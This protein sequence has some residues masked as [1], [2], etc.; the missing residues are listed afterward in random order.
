MNYLLLIGLLGIAP[1]MALFIACLGVALL[2][3]TAWGW[4]L[5]ALGAGYP[6]GALIW[7]RRHKGRFIR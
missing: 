4:V 1:V 3:E 5:L 7:Y 6:P 2:D